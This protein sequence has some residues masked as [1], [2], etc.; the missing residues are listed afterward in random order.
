M[1]IIFSFRCLLYC[2]VFYKL[3]YQLQQSDSASE[4][5]QVSFDESSNLLDLARN[6]HKITLKFDETDASLRSHTSIG[7]LPGAAQFTY[8]GPPTGATEQYYALSRL[9]NIAA[10]GSPTLT[11]VGY[12]FTMGDATPTFRSGGTVAEATRW[13]ADTVVNCRAASGSAN[14][15]GIALSIEEYINTETEAH[16]YDSPKSSA[17]RS[18]NSL[19]SQAQTVADGGNFG[20]VLYTIRT[21][22]GLSTAEATKWF[23]DSSLL[24]TRSMGIGQSRRFSLTVGFG[25]GSLTAA[26]SFDKPVAS[27]LIWSIFVQYVNL[28][29]LVG[30]P[31][32]PPLAK[33]TIFIA[34]TSFGI[35]YFSQQGRAGSSSQAAT[36][37]FSTTLV[38]CNLV[39]G[40]SASHHAVLTA[41]SELRM[42]SVTSVL[43]FDI[44]VPAYIQVTN[45]P[46]SG[47]TSITITGVDFGAEQNSLEAREIASACESTFWMSDSSTC[48]REAAMQNYPTG[49]DFKTSLTAGRSVGTLKNSLTYDTP[50]LSILSPANYRTVRGTTLVTI[51]GSRVANAGSSARARLGLTAC[52]RSVWQSVSGLLCSSPSGVGEWQG[53]Q[54]TI[55]GQ[56]GQFS[57]SFTYDKISLSALQKRNSPSSTFLFVTVFGAD[58]ANADYTPHIS[59]AATAAEAS[60]WISDS[61]IL[62]L[63]ACGSKSTTS[64]ASNVVATIGVQCQL[65]WASSGFNSEAILLPIDPSICPQSIGTSSF[66]ETFSYDVPV[67]I[68]ASQ[69]SLSD[70]L[71]A[72]HASIPNMDMATISGIGF[73]IFDYTVQSKVG[74]SHCEATFWTSATNVYCKVASGV[75]G[76][77]LIAITTGAA[78]GRTETQTYTYLAPKAFIRAQSTT[79]SYRYNL[80]VTGSTPITIQ[81]F[82]LGIFSTTQNLRAGV[83]SCEG[84]FWISDSN[85]ISY[86]TEG[87]GGSNLIA[88]TTGQMMGSSTLAWSYEIPILFGTVVASVTPNVVT[89]FGTDLALLDYT[90]SMDT[91]TD[92]VS[93]FVRMDRSISK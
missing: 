62:T 45:A 59:F 8:I 36:V 16:S 56:L 93:S 10:T 79:F 87:V 27:G 41:G 81:A 42:G 48:T 26:Y 5:T 29:I 39:F 43:S 20:F 33:G 2:L 84:S 14:T 86:P 74:S 63:P 28:N 50:S 53:M 35:A 76:S 18:R 85:I 70:A 82:F 54:V 3:L 30:V 13:V 72:I 89:L 75:G 7:D 22:M 90:P 55:G 64:F 15:A 92:F 19:L 9:S 12:G 4:G 91:H 67:P 32:S 47:S 61:S 34:G 25:M 46:M 24:C 51:I 6:I 49:V 88:V 71:A 38:S 58:M 69:P 73:G 57:I 21:V 1:I 37:W 23:S 65:V 44:P 40:I 83:S 77:F 78:V 11:I 31:N 68:L 66:S 80:P 60:R 17:L 52:E